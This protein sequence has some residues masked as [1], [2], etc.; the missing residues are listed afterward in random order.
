MQR[1]LSSEQ[2]GEMDMNEWRRTTGNTLAKL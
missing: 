1:L 2:V